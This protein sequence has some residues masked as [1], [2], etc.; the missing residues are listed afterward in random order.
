MYRMRNFLTFIKEFKIPKK[1][2]LAEARASFSPNQVRFLF[3]VIVVALVSA[4]AILERVNTSFMTT[5]PADGGTITEGIIGMPTLVNPVLALTDADKDLSALVYSGLMR[6]DENGDLVPDLAD[7][8]NPYTISPDG[9]MYTFNLRKDAKFQ[10]G[11]KVTA[12]DVIFTIGKIKD[13]LIK[14]PRKLG[15]DGIDVSKTDD[16]TVVFTLKQPYISFLDNTNIGILPMHIWKNFSPQEFALSVYNN[17]KAIGSGPYQINS[18]SKNSEGV[19]DRYELKRFADFVLGEPH[20]KYI[21]IAS[22]DNEKSLVDAMLS[23]SIDQ[24]SGFSGENAN[25]IDKAGYA[26][27]TATLPRIFGIFFNSLNNK[28]LADQKIINAIDEAVDR[29]EIVDKILYGYASIVHSPVP[30]TILKDDGASSYQNAKIE[31][32]KTLLESD[33]WV[34][35]AGG[36]RT[37]GGVTTVTK[38]KKVGKKTVTQKVT[39]NNGPVVRLSFSLSTGDTPELQNTAM[40]VKE[41]LE[42][43]GI[44]VNVKV[45][46]TGPLTEA[47]R[48]RSYEAV[49]YG[50]N[51]NH[52]SDLFTFW[53]SSQRADPGL[54]IAMYDDKLVDSILEA[55]QKMPNQDD[56]DKKYEDFVSE[57]NKN[58]P[59]ILI[60][61]P[62]YLYATLPKLANIK[63]ETLITPADR[64]AQVHTWYGEK[65]QVWKIFTR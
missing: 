58:V 6:K 57:F 65:D 23:N 41:Q 47:I 9:M 44:E 55:V 18:V 3:L 48:N 39:V 8:K 60:Y 51:I 4:L 64:F 43:I 63:L 49:F 40:L 21:N 31:D 42:K 27:H 59:A 56:R 2:E 22:Y 54:N 11:V 50:Q 19:P 61:S 17:T 25:N 15:W 12:D 36:I 10:D 46:E 52:E 34:E 37:K 14:S 1:S 30:E 28:I 33:G 38:T 7:P 32:A 35:G 20:I 45:Y 24:A 62:K 13:S 53:H 5:V 16:Y 26:I 29:Q